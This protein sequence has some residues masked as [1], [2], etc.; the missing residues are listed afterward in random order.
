M[1]TTV[2]VITDAYGRTMVATLDK[3]LVP[4]LKRELR[5]ELRMAGNTDDRVFVKEV[6]LKRR[7]K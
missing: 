1:A 6:P 4:E 7:V 2:Y 5:N 3:T